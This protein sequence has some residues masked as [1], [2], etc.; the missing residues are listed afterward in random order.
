MNRV[1]DQILNS[2]LSLRLMKKKDKLIYSFD[3]IE[4]IPMFDGSKSPCE[5]Y[6]NG[7]YIDI[8][9]NVD[10]FLCVKHKIENNIY[11]Y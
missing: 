8:I 10:D 6:H 3:N 9:Y 1:I 2:G 11:V 5:V 7:S 4:I